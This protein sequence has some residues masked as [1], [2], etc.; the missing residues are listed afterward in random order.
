MI[1]LRGYWEQ[2][3][4]NIGNFMGTSWEQK[5]THSEMVPLKFSS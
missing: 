2:L 4:E 5:K 3:G 1:K